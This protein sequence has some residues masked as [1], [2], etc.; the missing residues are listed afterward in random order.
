MV[1]GQRLVLRRWAFVLFGLLCLAAALRP[2]RADVGSVVVV[3]RGQF[4]PGDDKAGTQALL[5][6]GYDLEF[7]N[8]DKFGLGPHTMTAVDERTGDIIFDSGTLEPGKSTTIDTTG[9]A[10]G[11][12]RFFCATHYFTGTLQVI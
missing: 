12:Y 11:T 6:R 3:A 5:P 10:P 4:T 9:L 1:A 7:A 8:L 2:A